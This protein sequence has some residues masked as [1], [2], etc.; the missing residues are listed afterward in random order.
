M[1]PEPSSDPGTHG[2]DSGSTTGINALIG[3]IVG[4]V[5]S[6]IPFSTVI[7]G[8]VAGYLE[9][10]DTNDGLRVGALAGLVMLVPFVF[11]LFVAMFVFGFVGVPRALGVVAILVFGFGAVYTVGFGALGGFLGAYLNREL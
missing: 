10:G 11:L 9:G 8:V 3:G 7:G 5:L 2:S 6:F 4:I 1:V